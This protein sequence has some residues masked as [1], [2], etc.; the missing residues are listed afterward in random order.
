MHELVPY[1]GQEILPAAPEENVLR[2]RTGGQHDDDQDPVTITTRTPRRDPTMETGVFIPAAQAILTALAL[3]IGAGFLAWASAWSWRVPAVVFALACAGGWIWRLR[4]ADS[5]LWTVE[6]MTGRD[7]NH[8]GHTGRPMVNYGLIN[9][10][11]ARQE[12]AQENRQTDLD[13][14]RAALL[15]FVDRSLIHGPSERAHGIGAS[16]PD[17]DNYVACRDALIGLGVAVWKNPRRP[18]GGWRLACSRQKARNII[19]QHIL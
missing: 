6:T 15:A 7:L 18:K 2:I 3:A 17:R 12:V 1:H 4:L 9:P 5:L 8:D 19:E 16:G 11:V 14:K 13:A 10:R